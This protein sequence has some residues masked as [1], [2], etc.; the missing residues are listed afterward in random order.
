MNILIYFSKPLNQLSGGTERV[1]YILAE[2]LRR[3]GHDVIE[4][5]CDRQ[6]EDREYDCFYLPENIEAPTIKNIE[7]LNKFIEEHRINVIIN[8]SANSNAVFL[9]SHEFISKEIRIIQHLH[10]DVYGDIKS[11]YKSLNLPLNNGNFRITVC[12]LLKWLK[13]PYN[14]WHA[15]K[16]KK[17]RYKYL[18]E[19][20]DKI[21]V[22]TSKHVEDFK[23]LTNESKNDKI[24]YATNPLTFPVD[25][26]L[27]TF[28]ENNILF[29]GRLDYVKR[30]DR[31]L[32]VW[33]KVSTNN[34]QWRL[35]IIGSGSD[36][37]RLRRL[38]ERMSLQRLK[39]VGHVNP[40][41]YY[42]RAKVLLLTSNHEGTPMVIY[43]AMAFGVVPIVMDTFPAAGIMIKD[44]VDGIVCK[45]NNVCDM[46]KKLDSI[47]NNPN[48]LFMLG[49]NA[50]KKISQID[51]KD[52][53][54]IWDE[55]IIY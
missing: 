4:L 38:S 33:Q 43:E 15:L 53:L 55:I 6:D 50:K 8:E 12:N 37:N 20:S 5:A 14:R 51:N 7:F 42:S 22:L 18:L 1:A 16:W 26:I 19:H 41:S 29:V 17:R 24:V 2:Y 31:I 47:L 40:K 44:G 46:I 32:K 25:T 39:F 9:F 30:I 52:L 34:P 49:N 35:F 21:V 11:F 36:E 23:R 27:P 45:G 48:N 10:F 54:S 3:K 28:K 13:A